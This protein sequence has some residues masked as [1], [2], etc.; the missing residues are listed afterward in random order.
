MKAPAIL[1]VVGGGGLLLLTLLF[2]RKSSAT[3]PSQ[4]QSTTIT[5]TEVPGFGNVDVVLHAGTAYAPGDLPQA[6]RAR[7][8]KLALEAAGAQVTTIEWD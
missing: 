6:T 4:A 5:V 8:I 1:A 3:E 7:V 2:A